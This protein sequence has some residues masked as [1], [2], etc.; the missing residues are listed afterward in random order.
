MLKI[1][2]MEHKKND[3]VLKTVE[4]S[5]ELIDTLKNRWKM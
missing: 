1:S 2:L 4:T 5:R 3:E